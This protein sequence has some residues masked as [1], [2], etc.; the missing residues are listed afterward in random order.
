MAEEEAQ[1]FESKLGRSNPTWLT[2]QNE[3]SSSSLGL[4]R[5]LIFGCSPH[6]F[7]PSDHAPDHSN[8]PHGLRR[9]TWGEGGDEGE[10]E[11][12]GCARARRA[13]P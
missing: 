13:C 4:I 3:P 2:I 11:G 10:G 1:A 7:E 6:S 12:E 8:F 9:R 5:F